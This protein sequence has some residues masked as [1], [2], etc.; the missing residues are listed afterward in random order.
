MYCRIKHDE[1]I[2][3]RGHLVWGKHVFRILN[4]TFLIPGK[5]M[6]VLV[7]VLLFWRSGIRIT[8][9]RPNECDSAIPV[10]NHE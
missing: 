9:I 8:R 6:V 4:K 1:Q 5:L 3:M 10:A 2:D 7:E